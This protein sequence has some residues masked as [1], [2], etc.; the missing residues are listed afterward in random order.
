MVVTLLV[1]R[2][3]SYSKVF[4]GVL[5]QVACV[6]VAIGVLREDFV[7]RSCRQTNNILV[8]I[9][10][11]ILPHAVGMGDFLDGTIGIAGKA[12]NRLVNFVAYI[13]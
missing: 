8:R 6:I 4:L 3:A 12:D 5:E 7:G 1:L 13:N 9:V 2:K 10:G 11:D